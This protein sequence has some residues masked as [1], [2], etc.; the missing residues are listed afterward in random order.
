MLNSGTNNK[1]IKISSLLIVF[2]VIC[3]QSY[4]QGAF[5]KKLHVY[6]QDVKKWASKQS[7]TDTTL[8]QAIKLNPEIIVRP[9]CEFRCSN[10]KIL[11]ASSG[12]DLLHIDTVV[13]YTLY[14]LNKKVY[15]IAWPRREGVFNYTIAKIAPNGID[16]MEY[17][18]QYSNEFFK[19]SV[20]IEDEDR[21]I[22]GFIERKHTKLV[23]R[24][25]V[26]YDGLNDYV[27]KTYGSLEKYA[28]KS[29]I[30]VERLA[31]L[32]KMVSLD[33][34][35]KVLRESYVCWARNNSPDTERILVLFFKEVNSLAKL[36]PSQL[37]LLRKRITDKVKDPYN[38]TI[39]LKDDDLSGHLGFVLTY[40]QRAEYCRQLDILHW[41]GSIALQRVERNFFERKIPIEKE[42]E[43]LA[44]E[45]FYK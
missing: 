29:E 27:L 13:N 28:E 12:F 43:T 23:D 11:E 5:E 31:L 4:G 15:I 41:I 19:L 9:Y 42:N 26:L 2:V 8:R 44:K 20:L 40:E 14:T 6:I 45:V 7:E 36:K 18:R 3:L 24:D 34:C 33:D 22:F 38:G 35:K 10:S 21:Y 17:C 37:A 32:A 25:S 1:A 16:I 39:N 30:D